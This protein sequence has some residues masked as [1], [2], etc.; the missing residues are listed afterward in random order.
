MGAGWG[1]KVAGAAEVGQAQLP[2]I[3]GSYDDIVLTYD[4]ISQNLIQAKFYRVAVLILT[5]DLSYDINDN[6]IEVKEV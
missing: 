2:L 6:L 3:P 1:P 4:P 5:L